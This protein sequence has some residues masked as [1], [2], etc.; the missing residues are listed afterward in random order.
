MPLTDIYEYALRRLLAAC[1][2][3]DVLQPQQQH[4]PVSEDIFFFQMKTHHICAEFFEEN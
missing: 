2:R 1:L 3:L 4:P